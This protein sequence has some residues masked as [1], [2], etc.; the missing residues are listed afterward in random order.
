MDACYYE[1]AALVE[2]AWLDQ[3]YFGEFRYEIVR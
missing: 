2:T 3:A 1:Y